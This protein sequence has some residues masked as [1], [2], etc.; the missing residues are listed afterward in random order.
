VDFWPDM[1]ELDPTKLFTTGLTYTNGQ[2]ASC[3]PLTRKKPCCDTSNGC[4][5]I[6]LDGVF[7]Q[8]FSSELSSGSFFACATG[9]RNVRKGADTYAGHSRSCMTFPA[10]PPTRSSAR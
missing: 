5:I 7:L 4:V 2:P 6:N 3:I 1:T 9:R 10:Q 8:R